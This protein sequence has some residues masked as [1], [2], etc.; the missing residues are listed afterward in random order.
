MG[1]LYFTLVSA[2]MLLIVIALMFYKRDK[3]KPNSRLSQKP[4][5]PRKMAQSSSAIPAAQKKYLEGG[6]YSPSYQSNPDLAKHVERF[7][8]G[9]TSRSNNSVAEKINEVDESAADEFLL[10]DNRREYPAGEKDEKK[11]VEAPEAVQ[12]ELD[13]EDTNDK[14]TAVNE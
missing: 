11:A 14:R 12:L 7:L 6:K 2:L 1:Y 9:T 8:G 4:K 5:N 10:G 13:M 3:E